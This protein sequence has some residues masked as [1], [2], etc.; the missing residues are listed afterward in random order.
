MQEQV[1]VQ[2]R[3]KMPEMQPVISSNVA[4]IGYDEITEDVYVEFIESGMYLYERV[5][6]SVW[7]DFEVT[8]SKGGFV[9]NVLKPGYRYRRV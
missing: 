5:P 2:R 9:N 3:K 1:Q 6:L 4:A 7:Q 8:G